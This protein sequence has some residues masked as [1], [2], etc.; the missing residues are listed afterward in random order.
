MKLKQ[1]LDG[2]RVTRINEKLFK[3]AWQLVV[4]W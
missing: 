4:V 1:L 2:K 3:K